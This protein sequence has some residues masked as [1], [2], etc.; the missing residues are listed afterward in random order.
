[1]AAKKESRRAAAAATGEQSSGVGDGS[2]RAPRGHDPGDL[3]RKKRNRLM[4]A[5]V[6]Y[7][8]KKRVQGWARRVGPAWRGW[9]RCFWMGWLG[10]PILFSTQGIIYIYILDQ[11]YFS[12]NKQ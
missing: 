7:R 2:N 10:Y 3:K 11:R 1:M 9:V 6:G 4:G 8:E 12:A 5:S